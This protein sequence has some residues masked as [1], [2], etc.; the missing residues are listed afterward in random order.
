MSIEEQEVHSAALRILNEAGIH[1]VVSGAVALGHYTGLW[2]STKDLDLFLVRPDLTSALTV[3]ATHGYTVQTQASHWLANARKGNYYVDLIHGFGGWRAPIDEEWYTRGHPATVLGQ[4]VRV[5]PVEELIWI[6][7]YVAHRERF[8][9][10]DIL[11]LIQ[12]CHQ[13]LDWNHLLWRFGAH[14]DLLLFYLSLYQ[15]VYP[16]RGSDIP[17]WV[18]ADL[19]N[20]L[21]HPV[22]PPEASK[23][24]CRGTLS[25]RF[26]FL[27]DA[28]DGWYDS[29]VPWAEAQGW[30]E[31]DVDLDRVE[32]RRMV[33]D[34]RVRPERAA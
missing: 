10:A 6:K 18:K 2:R 21:H 8:D 15:F 27:V 13:T 25:D 9:G 28:E 4:S 12:S 23:K 33:D 29:R 22:S 17:G 7:A 24:V 1:Y 26:S 34:G 3:L 30:A 5:S 11:H 14:T 20:R 19:V 16:G 31:H 32:A